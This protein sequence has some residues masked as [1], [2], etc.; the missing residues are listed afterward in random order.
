MEFAREQSLAAAFL[1]VGKGLILSVRPKQWTKN[2]IIYFALFFTVNES[3]S[4]RDEGEVLSAVGRATLAVLLFSLISGAVY[5]VNDILD[6]EK[7]R[8]HPKKRFRPVASGQLLVPAAWTGAATLAT[9]GL[10][11]SFFLG[12]A[13]GWVSLGYLATM[14]VY[15]IVLKRM[16]LLD[17]FAISAGFVLRAVAGA[18]VLDAPISPWLYT[19]TG[20][21]A[22]LIALA[23]RR[24]ELVVAGEAAQS[25]RETLGTYSGALLDQLIA[26]AATSTLLAYIF[27]TFTAPNLPENHA[28]MLTI[29]FVLYGLFRYLYLIHV[30]NLGESPE[31][32]L[33]TDVP[34]IVSIVLW[35]AAAASILIAFRS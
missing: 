33:V 1:D 13:F 26:V 11:G 5:L 31:D 17:V 29:P 2:L 14:V 6:R 25:Q 21:G 30:R 3:W 7:D 22:L 24:S 16:V 32:I 4:I 20:L 35:L 28:M 12:Q 19:C 27:Y 9:A 18:V 15:S 10:I 34:L 23:K 8:A